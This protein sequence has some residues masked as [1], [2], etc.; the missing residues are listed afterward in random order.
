MNEI[1]PNAGEAIKDHPDGA[2]IM[3]GGFGLCGIPENLIAAVRRK[4][5]K[6]PTVMSNNANVSM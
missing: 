3:M 1:V 6:N 5:I 4:G 2:S